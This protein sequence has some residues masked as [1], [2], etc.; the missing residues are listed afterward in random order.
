[1]KSNGFNAVL[2]VVDPN[3]LYKFRFE[4]TTIDG[5]VLGDPFFYDEVGRKHWLYA[6]NERETNRI[7]FITPDRFLLTNVTTLTAM[8]GYI[9]DE[10]GYLCHEDFQVRSLYAKDYDGNGKL[11]IPEYRLTDI[12]YLK[13][14]PTVIKHADYLFWYASQYDI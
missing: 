8:A 9:Y 12:I 11:Y 6:I 14:I 5:A 2:E 13:Y 3:R 10:M 1:M 4:L 7:T